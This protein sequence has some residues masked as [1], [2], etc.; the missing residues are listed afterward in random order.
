[1][2]RQLTMTLT[3]DLANECWGCHQQNYVVETI[4]LRLGVSYWLHKAWP[5]I[6]DI[7]KDWGT[8][9]FIQPILDHT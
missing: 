5:R 8:D 9:K 2:K 3:I 1:M 7:H 6:D 4:K